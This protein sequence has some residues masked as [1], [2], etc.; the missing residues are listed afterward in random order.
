M[1]KYVL[2]IDQGTTSSR[3]IVLNEKAELIDIFSDQFKQ[4]YQG[5]AVLQNSEEIKRSIN[6]KKKTSP[7]LE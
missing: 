4:I 5:D 3:V 7:L 2:A 6:I 1:A